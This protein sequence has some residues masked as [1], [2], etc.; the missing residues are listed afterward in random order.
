MRLL[1]SF[2]VLLFG[3]QTFAAR[4][5]FQGGLGFDQGSFHFT[6]DLDYQKKRSHSWGAFFV[7]GTANDNVRGQFWSLGGD[8]KVYFGP[9]NWKVYLAPGLGILSFEDVIGAQSETTLGALY[10]VG[11]LYRLNARMSVGM[12]LMYLQN[13]F[14]DAL[15]GGNQLLTNASLRFNF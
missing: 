3:I 7:L 2:F 15:F 4:T 11:T 8:V 5:S 9:K 1:I 12:E 10:K 6:A 13:W 14:S